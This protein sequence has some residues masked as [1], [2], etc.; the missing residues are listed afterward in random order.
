MKATNSSNLFHGCTEEELVG[1]PNVEGEDCFEFEKLT[2]VKWSLSSAC[3]HINRSDYQ[4][5]EVAYQLC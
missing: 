4:L 1:S 2:R 3:G 5:T